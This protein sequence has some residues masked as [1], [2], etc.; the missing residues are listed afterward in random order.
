MSHPPA[1]PLETLLGHAGWL[2]ALAERLVSDVAE[3]DDVVQ[4]AWARVL[5]HPPR[6]GANPRAWLGEVLRN[7]ARTRHRDRVARAARERAVARPE[8]A[9]DSAELA[10]EAEQFRVLVEC[11]HALDEPYRGTVLLH[12]FKGESLRV[13]ASRQGVPASTVR[14]RLQRAHER[15]RRAL[16]ARQGDRRS[17][18]LALLP[19]IGR[20]D[21]PR[22]LG[23]LA[24][25]SA[26]AVAAASLAWWTLSGAEPAAAPATT[27]TAHAPASPPAG[28]RAAAAD[29]A[30]QRTTLPSPAVTG[31]GRAHI[32]RVLDH[33]GRALANVGLRF[34]AEH[35]EIERTLRSDDGGRFELRTAHPGFVETT[36]AAWC[37]ALAG[38][39]RADGTDEEIVVVAAPAARIAGLVVAAD[40]SPLAG[41][42]VACQ[43][44]AGFREGLAIPLDRST[45]ETWEATTS[46]SGA[47]ELARLPDLED[48]RVRASCAGHV[49]RT[50]TLRELR[51]AGLVV[52]LAAAPVERLLTGVVLGPDGHPAAGARV[53]CGSRRTRTDTR[54]RF[55]LGVVEP[56]ELVARLPGYAPV[57]LAAGE[58]PPAGEEVVLRL[59]EVAFDVHGRAV[60]HGGRG[61]TGVRVWAQ[62]VEPGL[63]RSPPQTAETASDGTFS[64]AGLLDG[65]YRLVAVHTDTLCA[66][67]GDV[68]H[69]GAEPR[70]VLDLR[71]AMPLRGRVVD[72]TGS[73]VAGATVR[74]MRTLPAMLRLSSPNVEIG[75]GRGAMS[76]PGGPV[77]VRFSANGPSARADRDGHFAL[78]PI[79]RAAALALHVIGP[80]IAETDVACPETGGVV[81]RVQRRT[82]LQVELLPPRERADAGALVDAA[83]AVLATR[84]DEGPHR[85]LYRR[86]FPLHEGRSKVLLAPAHAAAL[87]L[88]L[89]DREIERRP[90]DL[91]PGQLNR[92]RF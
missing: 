25:V 18:A 36:G 88:Y 83:G 85:L 17:W 8:A 49:E 47:F 51:D 7:A 39:A 52:R 61:L 74:A 54:G 82:H 78:P 77:S 11:V 34:I 58:L 73:P 16:D 59:R 9:G 40:E 28:P 45:D 68:V 27:P 35:A 41:A 80:G 70:L 12:Y 5:R 22:T 42:T 15:L 55:E 86:R 91:R 43:L 10:A 21:A 23:P 1:V 75:A 31:S 92:L 84:L 19:L 30:P 46:P 89:G 26:L 32:G 87:V 62:E 90:L 65:R 6:H 63:P 56:T 76:V 3:A 33:R 67:T 72:D 13:I 2:R 37:T 60:D 38:Y 71:G 20:A 50:V 64:M 29:D 14:T 81:V 44:P 24:A 53:S 57:A 4:D 48:L 69:R 66:V 79:D